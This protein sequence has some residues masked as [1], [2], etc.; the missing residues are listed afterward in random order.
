[1]WETARGPAQVPE[2]GLAPARVQ[3]PEL[4][5]V[6]ERERVPELVREQAPV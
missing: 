4:A 6:R 5:Q 1:M 2:L 3:A